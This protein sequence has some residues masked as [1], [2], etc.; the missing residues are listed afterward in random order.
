MQCQN[1]SQ[2][3]VPVPSRL[4]QCST[5]RFRGAAT[6]AGSTY[7]HY[8]VPC[9][10][11]YGT[12][13]SRTGFAGRLDVVVCAVCVGALDLLFLFFFFLGVRIGLCGVGFGVK[14]ETRLKV[15]L[16]DSFAC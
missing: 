16:L 4:T 8:I 10:D 3:D 14:G 5:L 15:P 1:G 11:K 2:H 13:S 6:P 12:T 7:R 9:E